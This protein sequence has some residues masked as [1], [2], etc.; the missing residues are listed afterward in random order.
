MSGTI[1][2]EWNGTVLTI[3]SDSGT[4]SADLKGTK[5]DTGARGVRGLAGADGITSVN[6]KKGDITLTAEDV[7]AEEA[8]TAESVRTQI[9]AWVEDG[10]LPLTGGTLTGTLTAKA[11]YASDG[12][13]V[14]SHLVAQTN[15][16]PEVHFKNAAGT[17]LAEFY[18]RTSSGGYT[19]TI[20]KV[21]KDASSASH[22]FFRKDGELSC[23]SLALATALPI[24]S[25]GTGATSAASALANLG[26]ASSTLVRGQ[27]KTFTIEGDKDHYYPVVFNVHSE[28]FVNRIA[29]TRNYNDIAPN[30]WG[31][32]TNHKGGLTFQFQWNGDASWGGNGTSTSLKVET[33]IETYCKMVGGMELST[34]GVVVWLRGGSALYKVLNEMGSAISITPYY[35]TF[36]DDAGNSF[37]VRTYDASVVDNEIKQRLVF[38]PLTGGNLLGNLYASGEISGTQLYSK[39]NNYPEVHFK[40]AAGTTLAEFYVDTTS[41]EFADV[42]LKVSSDASTNKYFV[43]GKN[44][45]F[46]IPNGFSTEIGEFKTNAWPQ[47]FFR[48]RNG[49]N[50]AQLVVPTNNGSY[51]GLVVNVYSDASNHVEYKFNSDGTFY[52]ATLAPSNALGIAYGGTGA[53]TASGALTNLGALPLTGGTLTGNLGVNGIITA[54]TYLAVE[55][56]SNPQLALKNANSNP[57]AVLYTETSD[58]SYGN[59]HLQVYK[60]ATESN[61]FTFDNTGNFRATMLQVD[62]ANN[63]PSLYFKCKSKTNPGVLLQASATHGF[64]IYCYGTDLDNASTR[65]YEGYRFPDP[66]T[67][68]TENKNYTVYS[69]KNIIYSSSQPTGVKGAIWLKPV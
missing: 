67:G 51:S 54:K 45:Y 49:N 55:R 43:F 39:T 19:D 46:G 52:C 2:H 30:D 58:G 48:N 7:G 57:L 3:T 38:Y 17:T 13:V 50:L 65:Y 62:G 18:A 66:A 10:Y 68:L 32:D 42:K 59:A 5:G 28:Y 1:T 20:L 60:S 11:L 23:G 25:G 24:S 56:N 29:I 35:N 44:G 53:T 34:F 22:F 33:L 9:E 15:N 36:T 8:G 12:N 41:G 4:S 64:G 47:L 69:E 26:A 37:P 27:M 21:Y 40:N 16:Y 63:W 31:T 61:T 14:G 6:G